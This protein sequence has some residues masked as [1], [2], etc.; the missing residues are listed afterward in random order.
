MTFTI[1]PRPKRGGFELASEALSSPIW[2][3]EVDHAIYYAQHH[4]GS[5][6]ATIQIFDAAGQII[7]TIEH[8]QNVRDSAGTLGG[9]WGAPELSIALLDK[10]ING[11][12]KA[13]ITYA[14]VHN[15]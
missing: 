15:R 1:K 8:N 12:P 11:H 4:A 5:K 14:T 3:G 10:W 9:I 6:R 2:Y 13:G 7:E